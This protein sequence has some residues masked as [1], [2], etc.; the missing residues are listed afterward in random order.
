MDASP[1][2]ARVAALL[3]EHGLESVLI[4]NGDFMF[5]RIPA[6]IRKLKAV[7]RDLDAMLWKAF[8]PKTGMIRLARDRDG[9]RVDFMSVIGGVRAFEGLRKRAARINVG[10][11]DLL[12]A[13]PPEIVKSKKAAD[14]AEG[15]TKKR[16]TR[17]ARL[18]ALKRES[19]LALRDQIR[20][21][22]ALPPEKRTN[23]LRRRIGP[24]MSCL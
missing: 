19:E 5:R 9:L 14:R 20:R 3:E 21:L 12:V 6:N 18:E 7:A 4:G 17:K 22:L 2:L 1:L 8:Y 15:L 24:G 10:G 11:A 16:V 23:F 13:D